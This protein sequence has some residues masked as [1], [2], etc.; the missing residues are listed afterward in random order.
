MVEGF[1]HVR[2][3]GSDLGDGSPGLPLLT[4]H[5]AISRA[6]GMFSSALIKV[7]G[8]QYE[9]DSNTAAPGDGAIVLVEGISLRGGYNPSDWG[10][11]DPVAYESK[12][13]DTNLDSTGSSGIINVNRTVYAPVGVTAATRVEGLTVI[14]SGGDFTAVFWLA[15]SPI[16]RGNQIQGGVCPSQ[17]ALGETSRGIVCTNDSTPRIVSNRIIGG[18]GG[19]H[20]YAI[21]N[22][23][24]HPHIL[25]NVLFGGTA[26]SSS[27]GILSENDS[28]PLI[29]NNLLHSG[30]GA[31]MAFA[32]CCT[33]NAK[34]KIYNNTIYAIHRGISMFSSAPDIRNNIFLLYA[35]GSGICEENGC[36]PRVENNLF[37]G[38]TVLYRDDNTTDVTSLGGAVVTTA[39]EPDVTLAGLGN[40]AADPALADAD[41]PDDDIDTMMD[42]DWHLTPATATAVTQGGQDLS[43]AFTDDYDGL[44]RTVPWSI[45][46]HE[47]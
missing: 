31:G 9:F 17:T 26:L 24:A 4:V 14:G 12:L 47:R 46:A 27:F 20:A 35:G 11:W 23:D 5:E 44:D 15:G 13:Q 21:E 7:A 30:E 2:D 37:H 19:H 39:A 25:R 16:V 28:E 8:G 33:L 45:G 43:S 41:G 42:N 36:E 38:C 29:A 3:D 10:D 18:S 1:L 22:I 40:V 6:D 34:A 32:I